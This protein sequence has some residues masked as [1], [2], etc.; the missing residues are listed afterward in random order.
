[1]IN[2]GD[3]GNEG[4]V[5]SSGD[6]SVRF[7]FSNKRNDVITEEIPLIF[8]K[9]E[10]EPFWPWCFVSTTT[11]NCVLDFLVRK[12]RSRK[13][14]SSKERC[15][16]R[17]LEKTLGKVGADL[18]G[19]LSL[20][21]GQIGEEDPS[22]ERMSATL[23][24]GIFPL[25]YIRIACQIHDRSNNNQNHCNKSMDSAVCR[26]THHRCSG[27]AAAPSTLKC[28]TNVA[29]S[30]RR[31]R[32]GKEFVKAEVACQK[33]LNSATKSNITLSLQ[34]ENRLKQMGT[35]I[36]NA[37]SYTK[38]SKGIET[39]I[40]GIDCTGKIGISLLMKCISTIRQLVYIDVLD[41]MDLYGEDCLQRPTTDVEKLYAFHREKHGFSRMLG[42][43]D[44]TDWSYAQ[45]PIVYCAQFC[46]GDHTSDPFNLLKVVASQ[47]SWIWHH[48]LVFQ[49]EQRYQCYAS[50]P[51]IQRSQK[52]E[53]NIDSIMANDVAFK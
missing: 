37:S 45:C 9:L 49:I 29:T 27:A 33:K 48:S 31:C 2:F 32:V 22:S 10:S 43:I 28:G 52:R 17:L 41:A 38:R 1:I 23:S 3:K 21:P 18:L 40:E 46:R 44:C 20:T 12:G 11:S 24:H 8:N 42:S 15:L 51:Y 14:I 5:A 53:S 6:N 34:Q 25:E 26:Q 13:V 35:T 16:K 36:T 50:I 30:T 19:F 4:G 39:K 47:D 7:K